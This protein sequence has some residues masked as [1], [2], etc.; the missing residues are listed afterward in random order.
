[1]FSLPSAWTLE[2]GLSSKVGIPK[3]WDTSVPVIS[4][5]YTDA[6]CSYLPPPWAKRDDINR[7]A[8]HRALPLRSQARWARA[9]VEVRL[10]LNSRDFRDPRVCLRHYTID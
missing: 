2:V 5:T 9:R 3:L 7:R 10:G 1:M 8:L 4:G 6:V